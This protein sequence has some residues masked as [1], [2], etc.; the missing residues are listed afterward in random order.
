MDRR[1]EILR[2]A[3][4]LNPP[5]PPPPPPPPSLQLSIAM[6]KCNRPSS[7]HPHARRAVYVHESIATSIL[8][9][10][11][12]ARGRRRRASRRLSVAE[13]PKRLAA[14]RLSE[15]VSRLC[16]RESTRRA[17][18]TRP[19]SCG[20]WAISG[21]VDTERKCSGQ[22][23]PSKEAHCGCSTPAA[24]SRLRSGWSSRSQWWWWWGGVGRATSFF[25]SVQSSSY[26]S[27]PDPSVSSTCGEHASSRESSGGELPPPQRPTPDSF[28]PSR[29][30]RTPPRPTRPCQP[31]AESR[32][33]LLS[34]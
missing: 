31:S 19:R 23:L 9:L 30:P 27:S 8:S 13:R 20:S 34:A 18:T 3:S 28:N 24:L 26:S 1:G 32:L 17:V 11:S 10:T 25:I 5:P 6:S 4:G 33:H 2:H 7:A 12:S 15:S 22:L 14:R 29:A 21:P 16:D